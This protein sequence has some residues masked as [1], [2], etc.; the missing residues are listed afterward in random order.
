MQKDLGWPAEPKRALI[1][2]PTGLTESLGGDLFQQTIPGILTL[3]VELVI[4]GKG[5]KE[6]GSFVTELAKQEDHR[7]GIIQNNEES[8]HEMYRACDAALFLSDPTGTPELAHCLENGVIPIAPKCD[9]LEDYDPIHESGT[10]FSYEKATP[11]H[12][13]A[14]MVR[15]LDTYIFPY[16]WR[17][18]QKECVRAGTK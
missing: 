6:H 9:G 16:D 4:V 13:F 2:L 17:T 18:I 7:V 15:A 12:T 11:W 5:S 8:L 10:T 14:A 1:C 3:P